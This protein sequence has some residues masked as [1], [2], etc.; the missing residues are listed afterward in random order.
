MSSIVHLIDCME[1]MKSVP[2]KRYDLAIVDPPYGIKADLM[3]SPGRRRDLST[4]QRI[5]KARA[6]FSGTCKSWDTETPKP[7]YFNE[8]FRISKNQI[9]WGGN[10]FK[11]P[12]TRGIICWDKNQL[13]QDFS[14]WEYAWTSFN[15][16]AKIFRFAQNGYISAGHEEK[17]HPTQKPVQLYQWLLETFGGGCSTVFDSHVGSGSSRIACW[18]LG[19]DFEGCE[20]DPFYFSLEEK[21]FEERIKQPKL[22][23]VKQGKPEEPELFQGDEDAE[24]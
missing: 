7:E 1:F 13:F 16:P 21:R 3:A 12:P 18:E 22:F 23:E 20:I 17:I 19:F 5:G 9:I 2:D 24:N 6:E 15:K 14:A 10:Y 4:A 11:L 8:L